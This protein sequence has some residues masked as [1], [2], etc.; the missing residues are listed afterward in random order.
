MSLQDPI[1]SLNH[2]FIRASV[3]FFRNPWGGIGL[4]AYSEDRRTR[5]KDVVLEKIQEDTA[6]DNG[7]FITLDKVQSQKLMDDLWNCGIR[8][9]EGA[10]SAGSLYATEQHLEDM[11]AIVASKLSVTLN[12][13]SNVKS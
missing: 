10:G 9:T 6:F 12:P 4:Y 7:P 1:H 5:V 13:K 2:P 8:P 3:D 11:R